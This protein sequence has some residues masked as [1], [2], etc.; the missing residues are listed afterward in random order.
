M[1]NLYKIIIIQASI[2]LSFYDENDLDN[3]IQTITLNADDIGETIRLPYQGFRSR[4]VIMLL[5]L[6]LILVQL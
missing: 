6:K 1:K 2:I 4:E 5:I 3:M